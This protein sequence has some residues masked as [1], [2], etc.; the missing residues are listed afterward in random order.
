MKIGDTVKFIDGL[1]DDENGAE[2][3]VIEINDDRAIIQ[4]ICDLP[5]PP[6]SVAKTSELEVVHNGK[7][8]VKDDQKG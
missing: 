8:G 6:R 5:I 2:Y 7:Y 4:F 1:Y 3:K